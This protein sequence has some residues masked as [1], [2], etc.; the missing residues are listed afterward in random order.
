MNRLSPSLIALEWPALREHYSSLCQSTPGKAVAGEWL[1]QED[2]GRAQALLEETQE[3]LL[4]S[5]EKSFNELSTL[6][7]LEATLSRLE[8]E[9]NCTAEEL[10]QLS[11]MQ[12]LFEGM[13]EKLDSIKKKFPLA[14]HERWATFPRLDNIFRG[15]RQAIEGPGIVRDQAS[16]LLWELRSEERRLHR[17]A[18]DRIDAFT[19]KAF[20]AGY[21]QENFFDFRDGKYIVPVKREFQS[22]VEGSIIDASSTRASIFIEPTELR[23]LNQKLRDLQWK[24]EAEVYRILEETSRSLFPHEPEIRRIYLELIRF[25]LMLGRA[26]WAQQLSVIKG[27][28]LPRFSESFDLSG[29]YH[30]LLAHWIAPAPPVAND[31]SLN[32]DSRVLVISGPNTGGKTVLMKAVGLAA[33]MARAGFY[34]ACEGQATLPFLPRV[35]ALVGDNQNLELSLSSFSGSLLDLK[36]IIESA[37]EGTLVL[38]DEILHATD[39]NEAS[40]LSLAILKCLRDLGCYVLVTTHLN[41]LKGSVDFS[42]ASMEFDPNSLAPTYRLRVGVPGS[43]RALE[44]AQK[45]GLPTKIVE[46]ARYHLPE[47]SKRWQE[48]VDHLE[49]EEKRNAEAKR[50]W[51]EQSA[52][53]MAR[54]QELEFERER[55][56]KKNW[57]AVQ[58]ALADLR[59]LESESRT[60]IEKWLEGARKQA[61]SVEQKHAV[62]EIAKEGQDL[63][64][65]KL[66][67]TIEREGGI[68]ALPPVA[69][70]KVS[71]LPNPLPPLAINRPVWIKTLNNQGILLTDPSLTKQPAEVQVGHLRLKVEWKNLTPFLAHSSEAAFAPVVKKSSASQMATDSPSVEAELNLIGRTKEDS[72]EALG[73]YLDRAFRSG[74]ASVRIVH[75]HGS[76]T[77]REAVRSFLSKSTYSLRHRPGLGNE[78][79]QGVTIVEFF[80]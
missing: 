1:P 48:R 18:R 56:Q 37:G 4:L 27:A 42:D 38:I 34:V 50:F 13:R 36:A 74:R 33:L 78:G 14:I 49:G 41:G 80:D 63:V 15:L 70:V 39:P 17:E 12:S 46:E 31:F 21:L 6:S 7:P 55:E 24:I 59:R 9:A 29:L 40:A 54:E 3:G 47:L 76:G 58:G 30:P 51:E 5:R 57:Q 68:E 26:H 65:T 43:S 64:R 60:A 2:Q 62:A 11:Q 44:I 79:G 71:S 32:G 66:R 53:L 72:L 77:L 22:Q 75:G 20:R 67:N 16:P 10:W 61:S 19:Q 52:K 28:A 8:K 35:E 25:D 23:Q 73:L 45:L 69:K